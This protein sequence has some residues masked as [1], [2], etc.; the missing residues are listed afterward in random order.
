MV[1]PRK[2]IDYVAAEP[3]RAFRINMASG[4]TFEIQHPENIAVA[5]SSA[6]IFTPLDDSANDERWH[7]VSLLL[8]ESVEPL[9]TS[10]SKSENS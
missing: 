2:L 1:T 9:A 6:K 3:F 10:V 7:D 4:K 5:R 8:M